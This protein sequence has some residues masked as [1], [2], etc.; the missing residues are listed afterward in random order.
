MIICAFRL[1]VVDVSFSDE[2]SGDLP[3]QHHYYYYS[4]TSVGELNLFVILIFTLTRSFDHT[5]FLQLY[6]IA[7]H[8]F[9]ESIFYLWNIQVTTLMISKVYHHQQRLHLTN[10][11]QVGRFILSS[12]NW[13]A[14]MNFRKLS[15]IRFC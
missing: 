2:F 13:A 10:T 9:D 15:W 6:R 1:I 8:Y 7:D 14:K 12:G 5:F 4:V 3:W 11:F